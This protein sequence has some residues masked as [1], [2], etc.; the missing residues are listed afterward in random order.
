[1]HAAL[2]TE[3]GSLTSHPGDKFAMR[4][5]EPV[6]VDKREVLPKETVFQGKV[7]TVLAG[8]LKTHTP[9]EVRTAF[10]EVVLPDGRRFPV[11]VSPEEQ[12]RSEF[13]TRLPVGTALL[14][15]AAVR[16][17]DFRWKK[18]RTGWLRL[19]FDLKVPAAIYN[20][21]PAST[22]PDTH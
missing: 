4:L 16:W 14:G 3:I 1:M 19:K 8:D 15:S 6:V 9:A 10:E 18:G 7:L 21:K 17:D 2:E 12:Q 22:N 11:N 5:V 20:A 13:D